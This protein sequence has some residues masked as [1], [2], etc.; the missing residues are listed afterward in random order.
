M[1]GLAKRPVLRTCLGCRESKEK[2][3]LIRLGLLPNGRL[4]ADLEGKLSGRGAYV[5]PKQACIERALQK[6]RLEQAFRQPIQAVDPGQ[7]LTHLRARKQE[8]IASL[9]GLAQR[10]G[11]L[12][13]GHARLTQAL[14]RGEVFFL[15]LAED[16]APER[17][18]EYIR[19]CSLHQIVW[20]KLFTKTELGA[21]IGKEVRSAVGITGVRIAQ[22]VATCFPVI[23]P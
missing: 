19:L 1:K 11:Q 10:A 16:I 4:Y 6:K 5:C 12:V 8:R 14:E 23:I 9:L 18:A 15:L 3:A 7:F 2:T 20:Q 22:N 13:S 17:E 21:C